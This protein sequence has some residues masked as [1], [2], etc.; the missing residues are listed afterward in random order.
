M[1]SVSRCNENSCGISVPG[2]FHYINVLWVF[3]SAVFK[4]KLVENLRIYGDKFSCHLHCLEVCGD[5]VFT[6]SVNGE[7][8][9]LNIAGNALVKIQLIVLALDVNI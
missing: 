9:I 1:V 8:D 7:L 4:Y 6:G 3:C 2:L 5:S